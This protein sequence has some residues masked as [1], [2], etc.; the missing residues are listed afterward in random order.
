MN[1]VIPKVLIN[2]NSQRD[3]ARDPTD[4]ILTMYRRGL[5]PLGP[6]SARERD[7]PEREETCWS[8]EIKRSHNPFP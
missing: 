5:I 6:E 8:R 3:V 1:Y 4:K 7:G 2:G